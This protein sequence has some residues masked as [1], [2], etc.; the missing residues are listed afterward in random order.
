MSTALFDNIPEQDLKDMGYASLLE[1]VQYIASEES[2]L[3][4]IDMDIDEWFTITNIQ[5]VE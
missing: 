4:I 3:D 1:Y 2:L 5:D